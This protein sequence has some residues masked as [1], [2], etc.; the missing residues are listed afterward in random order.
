MLAFLRRVIRLP[1]YVCFTFLCMPIQ[2]VLLALRSPARETFPVWYHRRCLKI[3]GIEVMVVG[4]PT[5][6]RPVLFVANH[7]SIFDIPVLGSIMPACFIAKTEVAG[8]PMFGWCAK[9]QRTLFVDRRPSQAG[10]QAD[11]LALRLGAGD[12]MILF[13]EGIST[14]GQIVAPFKPAFFQAALDYAKD[15]PLLIQP[16]SISCI[17]IEGLPAGRAG[18]RT[19]GYYGD[20]ALL[21][22]LWGYAGYRRSTIRVEF[23][24]A[25]VPHEVGDR[26][27]IAALS[28][29]AVARGVSL[30]NS[31]RFAAEGAT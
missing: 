10:V 9:L 31:G 18:R 15:R 26:K 20:I 4:A 30:A 14:D 29:D 12:N 7:I 21:P 23:H 19:Y 13:P 22:L 8:W 25:I 24:P 28:Y 16:L 2:V 11:P 27:K 1:V 5:Q 6:P 17:K 3:F